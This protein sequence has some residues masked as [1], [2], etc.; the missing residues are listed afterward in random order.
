MTTKTSTGN[1]SAGNTSKK[2]TDAAGQ[3]VEH[4]VAASQEAM[5]NMMKTHSQSY[6]KGF[7]TMKV[8]I[9][10][11]MQRYDEMASFSKDNVEA[12]VA[13]GNAAAK[14]FEALTSELLAF[15]KQSMEETV[16]AAKAMMG[17]KTLQEMFD[18]QST[19]ARVSMDKAMSQST[20]L[21]ELATKSAQDAV[22]PLSG[23]FN[24]A[25]EKF[26]RVS[27]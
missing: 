26:V 15:S 25:V 11:S 21:S 1:A 20:K 6:E 19:Y 17:A 7:A 13:S 23:R 5:D 27:A 2:M 4:V 9:D 22:E 18:L 14:G 8:R 16:A 3:A 24:L 10:E 12:L